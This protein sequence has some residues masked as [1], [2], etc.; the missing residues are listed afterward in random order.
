MVVGVV[1]NNQLMLLYMTTIGDGT[2]MVM[3]TI[4]I[5]AGIGI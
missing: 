4:G 3:V 5:M 1:T 2:I